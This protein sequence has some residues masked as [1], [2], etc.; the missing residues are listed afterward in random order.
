MSVLEIAVGVFLGVFILPIVVKFSVRSL[1]A[2]PWKQLSKSALIVIFGTA[3]AGLVL[4]GILEAAVYL[5]QS[6]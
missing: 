4:V 6:H 1:R 3:V 5:H 2:V